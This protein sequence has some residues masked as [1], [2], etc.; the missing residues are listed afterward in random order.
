MDLKTKLEATDKNLQASIHNLEAKFDRLADKQSARSS[1]SLPSNTQP[2]LRGSSPKPYKPPQARNK[3]MNAVFIRIDV[4][5]HLKQKQL[6][7]GVGSGRMIF[8]IDS[9]MKHSYSN[10]AI[11][12]SIDVIDEILEEYFNALLDEGSKIFYSIEGTLLKDKLFS[13]FDEFI[14]MNIEEN[15]KP[16]INEEELTFEKITFD[17]D[18]KIKKS[19]VEPPMDLELKPLHDHIEY[20]FLEG[21]SFLLVII[22]SQLFEQ[23]KNKLI[24]LH[25]R[26]EQAFSWKKEIILNTL[27]EY[28]I[29]S[30]A[31]NRP[32]MLDKDLLPPEWSKLV[33]DVKLVKDWHTINFDQLHAYLKQHEL[34]AN[35][36]CLMR[37]PGPGIYNAHLLHFV[38]GINDDS[39]DEEEV[40]DD[41]EITH[42]KVPI[43]LVDDELT[44]GKNHARNDEWIDITMRK[45]AL[46]SS[47]VMLLTFQSHSPKERH[48]L[49]DFY[50]ILFCIICKKEDHGTSDHEMNI[51]SPKRHE[52]YKAQPYQYA[53]PSDQI[54]KAKAKPF[55]S[56]THCGFNGHRP[57]DYRNYPEVKICGSYDHFTSGHNRVIYI[58]GGVLAES[59]QSSDSLIG[60]KYNTCRSTLHSTTDH[61]EF[62]H[63]KREEPGP[64]VVFGDNSS[65]VTDRYGSI[66]YGGELT[67]FLGLQIK[68]DDKGISICQEQ[69][70]KNLLKKYE[71]SESSSV[72]TPMVPLNNLGPD[73]V[74]KPTNVTLYRGMI[75][76]LMYLNATRHGSSRALMLPMTLLYPTNKKEQGPLKEY[77]IKFSALDG[78]RHLNL[79]FNTLCS[80]TGLDYNN[81]KY[82]GHPEFEVVRNELGKIAIN[83]TYMDKTPIQKNSFLMA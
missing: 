42:V 53:S 63:F 33:T 29:L 79:D 74:G 55:P 23:N 50:R 57:D 22:S 48:S 37:E 5:I 17:T 35:E 13:E 75:G 9:I 44:V 18:Y 4:V 82:V 52:N 77:L 81:G 56:S 62:D 34:H 10:D 32:P 40:S 1:G 66:N 3:H 59:S 12:F 46:P 6:N 2:N 80:S 14:T 43:A 51:A 20:A 70:T 7:L 38:P 71:I 49:D 60:V 24:P 58:K 15:I 36:V 16:E 68:H 28:M 69:Y 47:E 64:K 65:C 41:K 27:A 8:S 72:K 39:Y 73:L 11:C 67:Y 54:L 45:G 61:N 76:S 83:P 25:K 26:H 31:E 78:Q 19:L 21:T 30:G